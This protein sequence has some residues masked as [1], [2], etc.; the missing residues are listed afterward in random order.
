MEFFYRSFILILPIY[1]L[2]VDVDLVILMESLKT[3][4]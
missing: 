1:S 2:L 4:T 3:V